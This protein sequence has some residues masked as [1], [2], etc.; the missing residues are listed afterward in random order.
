MPFRVRLEF[1]NA[2]S[3]ATAVRYVHVEPDFA[4]FNEAYGMGTPRDLAM[5]IPLDAGSRATYDAMVTLLNAQQL[6]PGSHRMIFKV[7]IET[8]DDEITAEFPALF[9]QST[10]PAERA[11]RLSPE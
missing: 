8:T 10:D 3:E 4:D 5:P 6:Q 7:R 1:T 9:E 11:L 2:G